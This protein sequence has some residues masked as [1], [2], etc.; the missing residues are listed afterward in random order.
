METYEL[1]VTA[2]GNEFRA[3]VRPKETMP[4]T[5]H[6]SIREASLRVTDHDAPY[7][8]GCIGFRTGKAGHLCCSRLSVSH[9][10]EENEN[11][12]YNA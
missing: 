12:I 6:E 9:V 3:A 8:G 11:G 5:L 1:T 2:K 10:G 4:G 7:T